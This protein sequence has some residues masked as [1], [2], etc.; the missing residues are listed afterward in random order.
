M[1]NEITFDDF[2]KL[3]VRVGR[4]LEV[5]DFPGARTPSFVLQ[6]DLGSELGIKKSCARL[7]QRYSKAELEGQLVMCVINFP[8]R[9]VGPHMSEVLVLA[10]PD[11]E[12][13]A[14]IIQPQRDVPLGGRL[15]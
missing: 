2:L 13:Q 12:E 8:P 11:H 3:D 1:E 5:E 15:Y 9:Q 6:I 7:P 10:A 14:I 4:V